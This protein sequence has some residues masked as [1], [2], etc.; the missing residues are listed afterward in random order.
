MLPKRRM[1]RCRIFETAKG[2]F[3]PHT[4]PD[5]LAEAENH[6]LLSKIRPCL[7]RIWELLTDEEALAFQFY[8][9][10]GF[11]WSSTV[12]HGN[13]GLSPNWV[14]KVRSAVHI[15]SF[16]TASANYATTE[17]FVLSDGTTK[18]TKLIKNG[19]ESR[20]TFGKSR[21]SLLLRVTFTEEGILVEI[22]EEEIEEQEV[23]AGTI[24]VILFGGVLED[25]VPLSSFPTGLA[26]SVP[27]SR[28]IHH[29]QL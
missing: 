29:C 21:I 13:G 7:K 6:V 27:E 3:Q 1:S 28:S 15:E 16:N 10:N 22:P 5:D 24:K 11:L 12:D 18:K 4:R 26:L 9:E 2:R 8:N 23:C 19:F 14:R 17:E 25:A 20:I